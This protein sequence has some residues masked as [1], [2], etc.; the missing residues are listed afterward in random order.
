M[1][2]SLWRVST[3]DMPPAPRR[4]PELGACAWTL[5]TYVLEAG[6]VFG[7]LPGGDLLVVAVPLVALHVDEV[8][9]VVLAA[10]RAERLAEDVVLLELR[11]RF[12][13]VRR[14][15]LQPAAAE[16][17]DRHRVEVLAVRLA[18]VEPLVDAVEAGRE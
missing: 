14:E 7:D 4:R 2:H 18:G 11:R 1:R 9:D 13:E 3:H 12:V 15:R 8:V 5:L 17:R 6:Q 10:S 16:L